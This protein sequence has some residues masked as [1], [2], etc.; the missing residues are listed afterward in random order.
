MIDHFQQELVMEQFF[1]HTDGLQDGRSSSL[2]I[3]C[4]LLMVLGTCTMPFLEG[5]EVIVS[6][7]L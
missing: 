2:G 7:R 5:G 1:S 6:S 3:M 4:I